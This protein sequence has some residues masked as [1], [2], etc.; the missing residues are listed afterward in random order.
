METVSRAAHTLSVTELDA[1]REALLLNRSTSFIM[2]EENM[3]VFAWYG[4]GVAIAQY[5][6]ATLIDY[7]SILQSRTQL[8]RESPQKVREDLSTANLGALQR[9]M[10]KYSEF[11]DAAVD[12]V[13]MNA[14]RIELVH[15][16]FTN[17]ERQVKLTTADGRAELIAELK[18]ATDVIGPAAAA[19]SA[20]TLL[21]AFP[22]RTNSKA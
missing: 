21:A 3:E 19:V 17:H 22:R 16:W 5:L 7:L 6:E 14:L 11:R 20:V 9:E 12:L 4:Q 8:A 2:T 18:H 10:K 15:H 13:P 1:G